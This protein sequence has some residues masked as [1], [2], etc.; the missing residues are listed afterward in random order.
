MTR[1]TRAP[2]SLPHCTLAQAAV[3]ADTRLRYRLIHDH[4]KKAIALGRVAPGLVLVEAP[5]ARIFGTSRV[6]V[7]KAFEMLRAGGLLHT[8][9]GR[10]YLVAHPDGSV[11]EPVR[12]PLSEVTLGLDEA[13]VALALPSNSERIYHALEAAVSIGI[14]LR[15]LSHLQICAAERYRYWSQ[16]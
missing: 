11:A 2:V 6:P 13:P 15:L 5:V 8:F 10:G 1:R 4:L 3:D 16:T 7:R 12:A 14:A 9:E